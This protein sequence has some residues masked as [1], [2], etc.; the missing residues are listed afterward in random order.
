MGHGHHHG[1]DRGSAG[2]LG[3]KRAL[4]WAFLINLAFLIAEVVGGLLSGSLALLAD[5]GHMLSDVAALGVALWVQKIVTRPPSKRRT[6]GY[7]RAEVLS[8]QLNGLT[9]VIVVVIILREAIER[10]FTDQTAHVD[11]SIMLPIAVAG[12]LANALSAAILMSHRK[13]DLNLRAAFLHLAADAAGSVVAIVAGVAML[14]GVGIWV[15]VAA[16]VII[17]LLILYGAIR[18]IV[19]SFHILLEGAPPGVDLQDVRK[20]LESL[21]EIDSCHDL[22]AWLVGSGEP[23]LTAHLI[24]SDGCDH[25]TALHAA[26]GMIQSRYGIEHT[27]FQLEGNPC[28][29]LHE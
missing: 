1:H 25:E 15:D 17:S 3:A 10:T 16:S 6:Y 22:H 9:L 11:V 21:P 23:V 18:L 27:T 24:P 2:S 4:F 12:L 19:E 20:H 5:A 14:R 7:G 28:D 29:N 26:H 13:G 8:G